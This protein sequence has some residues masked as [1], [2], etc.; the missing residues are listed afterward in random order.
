M[1]FYFGYGSNINLVSLKAKGVI[2]FASEKAILNG[3]RLKFNVQHWFQHEGGMANIERSS[4][5]ADF[6]EG[7]VHTCPDESLELLDAVESYRI[8]YDRIIVEVPTAL[9]MIEAQTYIGLP[10]YLDDNCLPTKRYLNI[11][12][13]GAEAAGFSQ[14]NLDKL[15]SLPVFP[16]KKYPLFKPPAGNWPHF[17]SHSISLH[18]TYTALGGHVFDMHQAREKLQDIIGLLSRK[19]TTLFFVKRHDTSTG[20]ETIDDIIRGNISQGAKEYINTYL[21]EFAREYIYAGRFDYT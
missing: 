16:E 14:P 17:N 2:P 15:R 13:K 18:D 6:V 9:G 7:M 3:W 8:G 4:D 10:A 1:F 20:N 19:D 12:L 21:N 5:P 11:I